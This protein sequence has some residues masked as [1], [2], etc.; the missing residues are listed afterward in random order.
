M[1]THLKSESIT[2]HYKKTLLKLGPGQRRKTQQGIC[3]ISFS[4]NGAHLTL[5]PFGLVLIFVAY[6]VKLFS[7]EISTKRQFTLKF[8][9]LQSAHFMVQW[10][11]KIDN[12]KEGKGK[13]EK[14]RE[15]ERERERER[16]RVC[17]LWLFK[18]RSKKNSRQS[19]K[20][21]SNF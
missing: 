19:T 5:Q 8:P 20:L 21:E 11:K 10:Q 17:V 13:I 6:S 18:Q 12:N 2:F 3:S 16:V 9:E 1:N 7:A 14:E 15:Y 4:V